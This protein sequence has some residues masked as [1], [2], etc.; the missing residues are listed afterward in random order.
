MIMCG[1]I[2]EDQL[3]SLQSKLENRQEMFQAL[4]SDLEVRH[5]IIM[6]LCTSVTA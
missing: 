5:V 4:Q 2:Q 3:S 6:Y 1:T